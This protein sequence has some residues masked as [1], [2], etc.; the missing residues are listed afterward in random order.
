M[1]ER[2][3]C[4]VSGC[5][6]PCEVP[7]NCV[8]DLGEGCCGAP[9]FSERCDVCPM[10]SRP[11][12]SCGGFVPG[13]GCAEATLIPPEDDAEA[14][15]RPPAECYEDFGG[16]CCGNAIAVEGEC[17]CPAGTVLFGECSN[18]ASDDAFFPAEAC[19]VTFGEGCCGE[20]VE[21]NSCGECPA[22]TVDESACDRFRPS[23]G[24]A[25]PS[26]PADPPAD[27]GSDGGDAGVPESDAGAP[28]IRAVCYE[29]DADGCCG[30]EVEI[31]F[32]TGECPPGSTMDCFFGG[33]CGV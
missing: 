19:R 14:P 22:G 18:F 5:E 32:C 10:G 25:P 6:D 27:A 4:R 15:R 29:V 11:A 8:L 1:I 21:R 23:G 9:V 31:D 3:E 26:D 2:T 12:S 20:V 30:A 33:G 13:C 7:L 28:P 17:G 16:G 24:E